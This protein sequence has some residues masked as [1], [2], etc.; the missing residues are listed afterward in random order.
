VNDQLPPHSVSDEHGLLA[1]ILQDADLCLPDCSGVNSECFYDAVSQPLWK[2]ISV[3]QKANSTVDTVSVARWLGQHSDLPEPIS[4]VSEVAGCS[5]S[6]L[7]LS[8]YLPTVL[9]MA[10]RRKMVRG[11]GQ[12]SS[13]AMN[14]N[15]DEEILSF[16][17]GL[18][19]VKIPNAAPMLTGGQAGVMLADDLERRHRLEGKLTG[20]G[21]G[22]DGLDR[23]TDGLQFSEQT[24][25]GARPS[26]GK[27]AIGLGIFA[28]VVFNLTLPALFVSLEMSTA[29]LMR[30]M[31]AWRKEID[32]GIIR[33][34]TYNEGHFR[35][36][37][38]FTTE[39]HKSPIHILDGSR[40]MGIGEICATVKRHC[41]KHGVKLVVVDYLQ[42]IQ[43]D[44]R[45]EKRT[46]EV[47]NVSTRLH[48]L[49]VDTGAAF[50]TLAQ[51]SRESDKDKGRTPRLSDLADSAQIERDADTVL[52]IH[53]IPDV[54][55]LIVAK[56]RDGE[57]G[58]I[59]LH[60]NGPLCR[61]ENPKM[62]DG[63]V[64]SLPYN[65]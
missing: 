20:L 51:L 7:N 54:C 6:P 14:G 22:L 56:Q 52:L 21:T 61:F 43:P 31:L 53:R 34:G 36:F 9:G 47:A 60:F 45:H 65:D 46:Y 2:A 17:D 16:A 23:K 57:V 64:P 19:A 5:P 27:T 12:L 48:A 37:T 32:M 24:L 59:D 39:A 40:G 35:T 33:R 62:N 42:R 13:M 18:A 44:Q 30:R 15:T 26:K 4:K 41:R 49:A 29:A 3:L 55:Q 1:C 28:H 63:D 58:V 25:I 8:Q 50:L 38:E 10:M 11:A